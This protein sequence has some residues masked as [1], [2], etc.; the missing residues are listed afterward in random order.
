[1]CVFGGKAF[2]VAISGGKL[3]QG[4]NSRISER[5][6]LTEAPSLAGVHIKYKSKQ[7]G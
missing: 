3:A 7:K 2:K 5:E 4:P 6:R 1:M